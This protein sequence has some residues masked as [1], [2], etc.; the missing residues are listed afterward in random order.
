MT[1][2]ERAK[3]LDAWLRHCFRQLSVGDKRDLKEAKELLGIR[4]VSTNSL[5]ELVVALELL[6]M[7]IAEDCLNREVERVVLVALFW[8]E[9]ARFSAIK[10]EVGFSSPTISSALRSLKA[11][12]LATKSGH[13]KWI[14][15]ETGRAVAVY[16][17]DKTLWWCSCGFRV[18][19]DEEVHKE[20]VVMQCPSCSRELNV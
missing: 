11:V 7:S 8:L 20:G 2:R 6:M 16:V 13:G 9:P 17:L 3:T 14:L 15:T 12:G 5:F 10:D 1:K 18:F 19:T 4:Q